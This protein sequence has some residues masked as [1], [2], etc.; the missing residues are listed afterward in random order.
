MAI[1]PMDQ[2]RTGRGKL[3]GTVGAGA[4]ALLIVTVAQFEGKSN[5]PYRDMIG[6][7]T[8][9]YGETR[10]QMHRY[11]DDECKDMLAGG[12]ADFAGPVLAINPELRGHDPQTVAASS[13]AYNIGVTN[14]RR[15]TVA[16]EFRAGHW[17]TACNAFLSWNRAGGRPVAGLTRRR[18]AE[19]TICLRGL[20]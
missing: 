10:V 1:E 18:Q 11:S 5:T 7:A 8:V 12:L 4:A 13:L 16:R 2:P 9:C 20:P 3:V 19:R 6:V 15:S 17:K 14:Y